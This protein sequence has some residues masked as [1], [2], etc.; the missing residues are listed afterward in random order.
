MAWPPHWLPVQGRCRRVCGRMW[1]R[2]MTAHSCG[3]TR[4]AWKWEVWRR[5]GGSVWIVL[6][7]Y[8]LRNPSEWD[9]FTPLM[10]SSWCTGVQQGVKPG[11][12]AVRQQ[13][14]TDLLKPDR[15]SIRETISLHY[16]FRKVGGALPAGS[17][18][19]SGW[20][21]ILRGILSG[22]RW[23]GCFEQTGRVLIYELLIVLFV[24]WAMVCFHL[25]VPGGWRVTLPLFMVP[26]CAG[27]RWIERFSMSH[28]HL[29]C[30]RVNTRY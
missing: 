11:E 25:T 16:V 26:H 3:Y 27:T 21:G 28:T 22:L 1:R 13:A 8:G 14:G 2:S 29:M 23:N 9:Q 18:G 5:A 15:F 30:S 4:M 7:L 6:Y 19:R 10:G 20:G 12:I 24:W 17:S